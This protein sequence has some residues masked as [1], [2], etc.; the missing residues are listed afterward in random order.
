MTN[1]ICAENSS[2]QLSIWQRVEAK[3]I[4]PFYD[5]NIYTDP[6][7]CD[8]EKFKKGSD[9]PSD[10]KITSPSPNDIHFNDSSRE[11]AKD[12]F[13]LAS[14]QKTIFIEEVLP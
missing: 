4:T 3:V 2:S 5:F 6:G 11:Y 13:L 1:S 14:P 9:I 12:T 8:P 7:F 10:L